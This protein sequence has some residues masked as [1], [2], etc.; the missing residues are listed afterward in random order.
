MRTHFGV[1]HPSIP[2]ESVD[3]VFDSVTQGRAAF[4]V[5]PIENSTE[6][7]ITR[8]L[9]LMLA[10]GLRVSAEVVLPVQHS[11]MSKHGALSGIDCVLGHEQAL[12]QCRRWLDDHLPGVPRRTVPS[13]ARAAQ[14]ATVEPA[15]AAIG[16]RRAAG[17][18]GLQIA[19]AAIQDER[20][21]STRFY[22]IG[23]D[24]PQVRGATRTLL[25]IELDNRPGALQRMLA[26]LADREIAVTRL[27]SRPLKSELWAYRF[28]VELQ[29]DQHDAA[30]A[31]ALAEIRLA[32]QDVVVLG[33][34]AAAT[35]TP[36]ADA[37]R[38]TLVNP[39]EHANAIP[40]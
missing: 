24:Q 16:S 34:F 32:A 22:V 20:Q 13:N 5:V 39:L 8:T 17:H 4:G 6:G 27:D 2:C 33:S 25:C 30:V 9:D 11:L 29:R 40:N 36:A 1:A 35:D 19:A 23:P 21:N 14:L 28:F 26:P 10:R 12:G 37:D 38:D 7:V 18:Y 3:A 15:S 31:A